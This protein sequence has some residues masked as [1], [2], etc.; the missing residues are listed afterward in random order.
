ME[1]K[2]CGCFPLFDKIIIWRS[3]VILDVGGCLND[4]SVDLIY[5]I[6]Y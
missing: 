4:T 2:T 1:R 3:I 5:S 6:L